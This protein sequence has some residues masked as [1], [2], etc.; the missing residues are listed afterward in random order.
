MKKPVFFFDFFGV[1]AAEIAPVWLERYFPPTEA[2]RIKEEIFPRAD[3]GVIGED[4]LYAELAAVTGLSPARVRAEWDAS[5]QINT[6]LVKLLRSLKQQY[7]V[8][9][10]SNAVSP[11]LRRILTKYDL[12]PLFDH[13]FISSEIQR[14]KPEPSFYTYVT[15]F[16]H[17]DPSAAVMIDDNPKNIQGAERAGLNGILYRDRQQ[18]LSE[19][20][21]FLTVPLHTNPDEWQ[22]S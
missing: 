8:Y 7:P 11:F 14:I 6:E 22:T 19:L 21:P 5:V 18:F 1:V 10:L 16:L 13:V 17:I 4:K 2:A 9:L 15:D 20:A 3:L 12:F